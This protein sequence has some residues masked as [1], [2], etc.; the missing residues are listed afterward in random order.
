MPLGGEKA[1]VQN[2][3][4]RYAQD[5]GWTFLPRLEAERLRRGEGGVL[6]HEVAVAQLQKLNP[7]TVDHL[8]AE[9]I[10]KAIA[11]IRPSI[12]GNMAVWEYLCGRRT[13]FVEREKRERNL[14]VIDPDNI[15]RNTF[16]VTEEFS[17]FNGRHRIRPD[18]VFLVNG[19]PVLIIEAK[20]AT[21]LEGISEALEQVRRY[22][23]EGPE[24]MALAQV[25]G[26][27][28]SIHLHYGATWSLSAKL[29][30]NWRD[31]TD[32]SFETQ[33]KSFVDRRRLLAAI[34]EF[35]LFTRKDDDLSKVVLRPHQM[36]AAKRV[37]ERA[38]DKSKRRA[39]VWHTQGS[40]KTFT[41]IVVAKLLMEDPDLANPTVLML[42]DR[43]EL[44]AQLFANLEG[45]GMQ[46]AIVAGSK[47]QLRD[48]LAHDQRGL[49]VSMIHKFDDIPARVNTRSNIFVLV[50]EAHR[51]TG[52]DLGNYLMGALPNATYIGFT[53]TPIDR[54]AYGKGTFKTF[55]T[56]DPAGYL[57]KYSIRQ[58]IQDGTTVPLHY[59]LA[60]NQLRVDRDTLEREFLKLAILEGV[61]DIEQVNR[62]L[63]R[64]VNLKN[65]LK[66]PERVEL[67]AAHIAQHFLSNVELMGYKAFV[68]AVDRPACAMYKQALDRH[69][70]P[71][72]SEVVFSAAHNDPPELAAFHLSADRE[73]QIRKDFRKPDKLPKILIV[74]EKLL[75]GFDAPIL[76]CMYLD[77]P[78]RDHV[79]LQA[80]ARVNRPY[81]DTQQRRKPSGFVLDFVGI[82]EKIEDALAF[83]SKDVEGVIQDIE[84]LERHFADLMERGRAEYLPLT[85]HV[86]GDKATEA[87]VD[88]FRDRAR[89]DAYYGY[90][91][92]LSDLY[93]VL[94]PSEFLRPF[95]DDYQELATMFRVA[96]SAF[97]YHLPVEQSFLRKTAE[98]VS[99][100]TTSSGIAT[101]DAP[102][103]ITP[104]AL[105]AIAA[106]EESDVVRVVN[107][108][109]A[110]H[111]AAAEQGLEAPYLLSIGERAE[112]IAQRFY[113]RQM[114]TLEALEALQHLVEQYRDAERER[115][116]TDLSVEGFTVYQALKLDDVP[117]AQDVAQA[118]EPTFA[119]H[120]HWR[121]SDKQ[122]K[123]VRLGLYKALLPRNVPNMVSLVDRV[124]DVLRRV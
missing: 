53:G 104:E 22:H 82:F 75:T 8:R 3:I 43:N 68:V 39:L 92:D 23:R 56:D 107:L 73:K 2:P 16:H 80:I 89:R 115:R 66:N 78:M 24:L 6:L 51:T 95:L 49:V 99:Q 121:H 69:L 29:L 21:R 34:T 25:Y 110:L 37:V 17:F 109:K 26:L 90:F 11:G 46:H 100:Y 70:P 48:L 32:G 64:A 119:E 20:A 14:Q 118:V 120:P 54:T 52:G 9:E 67:V 5:V 111:R 108:V 76:Y 71:E 59:A 83:D 112:E 77:K 93:E 33:V 85:A 105:A 55:G 72:Y 79:L 101:P 98:L 74:T 60:P 35:V 27:T 31:E 84:V 103:A 88:H 4:L 124:L 45:V 1:G 91:R 61:S 12:E 42:V 114:T 47:K 116:D 62:A 123:E 81:E 15:D 96:R 50:D 36:R 87:V 18:V 30:F 7:A 117:G 86:H 28:H 58:S 57:D 102:I 63:E 113:D 41:M 40:G 106:A 65:M 94:S 44:E 13:V 97:E 122:E 19:L 38:A 10:I